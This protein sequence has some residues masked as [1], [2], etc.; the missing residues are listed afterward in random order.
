MSRSI[1]L[2]IKIFLI[3]LII[4]TFTSFLIASLIVENGKQNANAATIFPLSRTILLNRSSDE[5]LPI[6]VNHCLKGMHFLSAP[7][8]KDRHPNSNLVVAEELIYCAFRIKVPEFVNQYQ[9]NQWIVNMR[10]LERMKISKNQ[11]WANYPSVHGQNLIFENAIYRGSPP[12]DS[13][14]DQACMGVAASALDFFKKK[15]FQRT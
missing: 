14:S 7:C 3:L 10:E 2:W 11:E 12:A 9:K 8:V 1:K 15:P 13:W 4:F 6:K 5:W